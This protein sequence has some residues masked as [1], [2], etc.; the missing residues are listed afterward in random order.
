MHG[1]HSRVAIMVARRSS[2]AHMRALSGW[3][4]SLLSVESVEAVSDVALTLCPPW[5]SPDHLAA[6]ATPSRRPQTISEFL[7]SFTFPPLRHTCGP[8]TTLAGP[9][10]G[11]RGRYFLLG[12]RRGQPAGHM[13][14][15]RVS[16]TG[17]SPVAP[18]GPARPI[19]LQQSPNQAPKGVQV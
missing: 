17:I 6:A 9:C 7:A 10:T 3:R 8:V 15:R 18:G 19:R 16:S 11:A 1:H 5:A 14:S 4:G 13:S 2:E 12:I